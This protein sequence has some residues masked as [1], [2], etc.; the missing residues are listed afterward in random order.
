MD[1]QL[2]IQALYLDA[3][4][5]KGLDSNQKL[6]I[7]TARSPLNLNGYVGGVHSYNGTNQ[8]VWLANAFLLHVSVSLLSKNNFLI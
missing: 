8:L 5:F 6:K 7:K 3:F 1:M 2:W 4:E